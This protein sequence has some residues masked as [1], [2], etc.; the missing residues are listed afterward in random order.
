MVPQMEHPGGKGQRCVRLAS[1][2]LSLL[3]VSS[4]LIDDEMSWYVLSEAHRSLS[5]DSSAAT[6]SIWPSMI[7]CK[8]ARALSTRKL[9]AWPVML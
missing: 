8:L 2:S 5:H 9:V 3:L 1:R 6:D 4:G 7:S